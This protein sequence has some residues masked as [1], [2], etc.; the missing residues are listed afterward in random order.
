MKWK[1]RPESKNIEDRRDYDPSWEPTTEGELRDEGEFKTGGGFGADDK[2]AMPR[3][4]PSKKSDRE[5]VKNTGS[6]REYPKAGAYRKGGKAR[7][8]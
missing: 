6:K 1:G 2:V 8:C 5:P 4:K 3:P 7:S